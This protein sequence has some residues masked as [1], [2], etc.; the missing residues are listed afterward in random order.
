MSKEMID[1]KWLR[2]LECPYC[3][4]EVGTDDEYWKSDWNYAFCKKC[5]EEFEIQI[6]IKYK[7]KWEIISE[8]KK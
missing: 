6:Q 4:G 1:Q 5:D 3:G 8:I 2:N 7:R